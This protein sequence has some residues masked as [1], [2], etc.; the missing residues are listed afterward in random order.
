MTTNTKTMWDALGDNT[1]LGQADLPNG[2]DVVLTIAG[3]GEAEGYDRQ[4]RE[5]KKFKVLYFAEKHPWVKPW[6]AKAKINRDMLRLVTGKKVIEEAIGLKIQIGIDHNVRFGRDIVGG[7]RVRNVKSETLMGIV[8]EKE[9]L[10]PEN[11]RY[12]RVKESLA[13]GTT[14]IEAVE[15]VFIVS[16]EVRTLLGL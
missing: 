1:F 5:K 4:S 12:A 15:K 7:L 3:Y 6:I 9:V 16:G 14:T 11:P 13:A 8:K 10:T 2:E